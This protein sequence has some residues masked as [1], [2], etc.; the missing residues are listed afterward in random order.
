MWIKTETIKSLEKNIATS[1]RRSKIT[2]IKTKT[3]HA[4][5]QNKKLTLKITKIKWMLAKCCVNR[6]ITKHRNNDNRLNNKIILREMG[7]TKWE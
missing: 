6:I 5:K 2:A 7:W 4:N 1:D 3:K